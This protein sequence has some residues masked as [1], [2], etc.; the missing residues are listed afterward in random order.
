MGRSKPIEAL[1]EKVDVLLQVVA[2]MADNIV[3]L[4][5]HILATDKRRDEQREEAEAAIEAGKR[6]A[7]QPWEDSV[8]D[9]MRECTRRDPDGSITREAAWESYL[10]FAAVCRFKPVPISTFRRRLND[11]GVFGRGGGINLKITSPETSTGRVL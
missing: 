2:L 1:E 8:V 10:D 9:W 3:F 7:H 5:E 11:V 4:R 6:D